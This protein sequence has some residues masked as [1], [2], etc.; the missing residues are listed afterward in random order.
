MWHGGRGNQNNWATG[1]YIDYAGGGGS[2][3]YSLWFGSA[4]WSYGGVATGASSIITPSVT[5]EGSSNASYGAGH[6][7]GTQSMNGGSGGANTG[8]GGAASA[9]NATGSGY[10]SS[11]AGGSGVVVMR[12]VTE[13]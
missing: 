13:T 6:S 7:T 2:S 5:A 3:G 8:G 10:G 9:Y 11:G 4:N 12:W 1:S